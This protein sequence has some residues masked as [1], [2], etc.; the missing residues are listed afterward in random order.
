MQLKPERRTKQLHQLALPP[1]PLTSIR[2]VTFKAVAEPVPPYESGPR[3][4]FT[5][6]RA[7]PGIYYNVRG[8]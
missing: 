1:L 4:L 8:W 5:R 3:A 6:L 7:Q 2:S